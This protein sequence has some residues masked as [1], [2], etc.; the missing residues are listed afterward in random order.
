[1]LN[2]LYGAREKERNWLWSQLDCACT[3]MGGQDW[4]V[5]NATCITRKDDHLSL[6][7]QW[8]GGEMLEMWKACVDIPVKVRADLRSGL[9]LPKPCTHPG[10]WVRGQQSLFVNVFF[11]CDLAVSPQE[12]AQ[13]WKRWMQLGGSFCKGMKSRLWSYP[14]HFSPALTAAC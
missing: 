1:M 8:P 13:S 11:Q 14:G 2:N 6:N 10:C 4:S 7:I 5:E 3:V 12:G 9:L